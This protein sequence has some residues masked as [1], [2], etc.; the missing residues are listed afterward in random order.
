VLRFVHASES[1]HTNFLRNV[2]ALVCLMFF[3]EER[4]M[5]GGEAMR[6]LTLLLP[7]FTLVN[8]LGKS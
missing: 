2:R 5:L 6:S 7:S 3:W 4:G 1:T 8:G